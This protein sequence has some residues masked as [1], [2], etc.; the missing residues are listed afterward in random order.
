MRPETTPQL[1]GDHPSPGSHAAQIYSDSL[2]IMSP[3]EQIAA[4]VVPRRVA[5]FPALL[6]GVLLTCL[7]V[8]AYFLAVLVRF[9]SYLSGSGQPL[10]DRDPAD[11][12]VQRRASRMWCNP[13]F[14]GPLPAAA[15]ETHSSGSPVD[16]A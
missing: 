7:G 10:A 15:E 4:D 5:E 14:P 9:F 12:L 16:S 2:P 13:D 1:T 8:S 11:H 3:S 6:Y